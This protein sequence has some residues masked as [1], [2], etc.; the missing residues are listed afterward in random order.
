MSQARHAA[1]ASRHFGNRNWIWNRSAQSGPSFVQIVV[2]EGLDEKLVDVVP[3]RI[4][5]EGPEVLDQS[6]E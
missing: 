5:G 4:A 2:H 1:R 6:A 3:V